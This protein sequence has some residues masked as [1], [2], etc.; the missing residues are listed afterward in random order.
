MDSNTGT[1]SEGRSGKADR[2]RE[3]EERKPRGGDRTTASANRGGA[4]RGKKKRRVIIK[5]NKTKN[6][7]VTREA[8]QEGQRGRGRERV[9]LLVSGR[10]PCLL[11][12]RDQ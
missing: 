4:W 1:P 2:S 3:G 5:K 12:R 8:A 11:W 6:T 9:L 10:G 7:K